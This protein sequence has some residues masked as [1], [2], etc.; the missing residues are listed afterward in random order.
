MREMAATGTEV[1][2]GWRTM[3]LL[4]DRTEV[5]PANSDPLADATDAMSSASKQVL[6][7]ATNSSHP[8][9]SSREDRTSKRGISNN[10]IP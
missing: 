3:A 7:I 2:T 6:S 10:P 1:T 4:I 9:S 8:R 5:F